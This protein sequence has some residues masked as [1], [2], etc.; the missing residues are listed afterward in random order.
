MLWLPLLTISR[1]N[2]KCMIE[3]IDKCSFFFP[4]SKKGKSIA[5][6]SLFF[7]LLVFLFSEKD[8]WSF[9]PLIFSS[10]FAGLNR[11]RA[12]H[13]DFDLTQR[14]SA[15]IHPIRGD[16]FERSRTGLRRLC[17][18]SR[19]LCIC[20]S[21]LL[22][23]LQ[24]LL[25]QE[26]LFSNES[27]RRRFLQGRFSSEPFRSVE[28]KRVRLLSLMLLLGFGFITIFSPLGIFDFIGWALDV[29]GTCLGMIIS[30]RLRFCQ[31]KGPRILAGRS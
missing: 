4:K 19:R 21:F 22:D 10:L 5:W 23:Q 26:T 27:K 17:F 13:A 25:L 7:L 28:A 29:S 6:T 18:R 2:P 30:W 12:Q 1:I 8:G 3:Q 31:L 9:F 20:D 11:G 16:E 24:E 15:P 14:K